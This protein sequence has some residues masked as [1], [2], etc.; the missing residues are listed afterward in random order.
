MTTLLASMKRTR[1]A[2]QR[3]REEVAA[4]RRTYE[5]MLVQFD[6]ETEELERLVKGEKPRL[7][8]TYRVLPGALVP[9][10][11]W[12]CWECRLCEG[13]VGWGFTPEQA[14]RNWEDG[15]AGM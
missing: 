13:S 2:D 6:Q 11:G 8:R 10:F 14:Y 9:G 5:S 7:K 3:F 4:N 1:A 12:A 15:K